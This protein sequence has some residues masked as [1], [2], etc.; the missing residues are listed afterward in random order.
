[1]YCVLLQCTSATNELPDLVSSEDE[2]DD[3]NQT[4]DDDEQ[5]EHK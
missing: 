1:V 4:S 2:A 5:L 3:D